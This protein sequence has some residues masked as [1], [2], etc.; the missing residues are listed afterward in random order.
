MEQ[1]VPFNIKLV[2]GKTKLFHHSYHNPSPLRSPQSTFMQIWVNSEFDTFY[3][4]VMMRKISHCI[5]KIGIDTLHVFV[6][7][8]LG[9]LEIMIH[10]I[11]LSVYGAL[12]VCVHACVCVCLCV[13]VRSCLFKGCPSYLQSTNGLLGRKPGR[14]H[15]PVIQISQC[16]LRENKWH[17]EI[18]PH[19]VLCRPDG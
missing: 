3:L 7:T 6:Y 2:V 13:R 16:M 5:R 18:L 4:R 14:L 15:A 10:S 17:L 8:K 9:L 11:K 19:S 12:C 1:A